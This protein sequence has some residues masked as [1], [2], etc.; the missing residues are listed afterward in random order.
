MDD[1]LED[2]FSET[3]LT[4]ELFPLDVQSFHE[5]EEAFLNNPNLDRLLE[6]DL[7]QIGDSL[8]PSDFS[9][10][11]STLQEYET[12]QFHLVFESQ[13]YDESVDLQA[14]SSS[15]SVDSSNYAAVPTSPESIQLVETTRR[16][17]KLSVLSGRVEKSTKERNKEA[18][19]RYRSKKLEERAKLFAEVDHYE[20]LNKELRAK[21]EDIQSEV[22]LIK[23][24]LVQVYLRR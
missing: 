6:T 8:N 22:N 11:D 15:Y 17:T 21:I 24:L 14:T 7:T 20:N 12:S 19:Q 16:K 1:S 10:F 3:V 23:S 18:T 4:N 9:L 13:M 5:L 2:S